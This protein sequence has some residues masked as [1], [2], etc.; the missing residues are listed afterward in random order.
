MDLD[1]KRRHFESLGYAEKLLYVVAN[2]NAATFA[3]DRLEVHRAAAK[4]QMTRLADAMANSRPSVP[5]PGPGASFEASQAYV[6]NGVSRMAPVLYEA[7]FYFVAW[8]GCRNMLE[9]LVGQPEF[10]EAKKVFDSQRKHFEHYVA[11]RNS[12]EHFGD[13]L[14]GRTEEKRVREVRDDPTAGARRVYLGISDGQYTH[15][16]QA[17]DITPGSLDLLERLIADVLAIVHRTIDEQI[18]AKF[19]S[20]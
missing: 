5:E 9:I 14:P 18:G 12:F 2:W 16:D 10:L 6:R 1:T 8:G 20:A 17:W 4:T 15:S 7:H 19:T 3:Y 13:R 11:A